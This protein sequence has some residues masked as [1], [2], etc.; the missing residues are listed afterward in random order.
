[1]PI[2]SER[3][4]STCELPSSRP[5][6]KRPCWTLTRDNLAHYNRLLAVSRDRL[7][8]AT[9]QSGSV[10][11]ELQRVQYETDVQTAQV[12]LRTAKIQLLALLND[13][14]P[15]EQFDIDGTFDF[16][17]EFGA[18]RISGKSRWNAAGP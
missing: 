9:S 17:E 6:S 13:R 15:V 5:C 8:P 2:R 3:C 14:T 1:M 16:A 12:N 10:R 11:L 4:C 18:W 7:K